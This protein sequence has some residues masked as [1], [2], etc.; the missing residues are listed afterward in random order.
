[1]TQNDNNYEIRACTG[2][3]FD[4][5]NKAFIRNV[6]ELFFV[7][8]TRLLNVDL[9]FKYLFV[10]TQIYTQMLKKGASKLRLFTLLHSMEFSHSG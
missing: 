1:M 6:V 2:I 5:M 4:D 10:C 9:N 3:S 7:H 8:N